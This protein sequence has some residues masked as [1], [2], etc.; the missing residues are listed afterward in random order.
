MR[1]ALLV[2]DFAIRKA[3]THEM[4][5]AH[6]DGFARTDFFSTICMARLSLSNLILP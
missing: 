4:L 3:A 1:V 5:V 6:V 2:D